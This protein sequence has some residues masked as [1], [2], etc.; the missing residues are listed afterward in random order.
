MRLL[1]EKGDALVERVRKGESMDA[2]AASVGSQVSRGTIDRRTAEQ[3]RT[4]R[5]ELFS[6]VFSAK[7]NEVVNAGPAILKIEAIKPGPTDQAALFTRLAGRQISQAVFQDVGEQAFKWTRVDMKVKTDINRAR[8]A[9][10]L[11]PVA[12][13]DA[14]AA[15]K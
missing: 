10:G 14:K 15:K 6:Q 3:D 8:T 7:P 11:Q 5:R 1:Q 2:V 9:I 13:P 4:A 12:K